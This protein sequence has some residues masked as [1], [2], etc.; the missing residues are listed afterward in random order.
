MLLLARYARSAAI[1]CHIQNDRQVFEIQDVL[2][3]RCFHL[4][5][6]FHMRLEV[7]MPKLKRSAFPI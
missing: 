6:E 1:K 2:K 7:R 5:Q 3:E 4:I